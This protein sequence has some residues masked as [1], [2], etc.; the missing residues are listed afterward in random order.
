MQVSSI[1]VEEGHLF[2][3]G[4]DNDRMG[5]PDMADIVDGIEIFPPQMVIHMLHPTSNQLKRF[6]IRHA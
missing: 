4:M 6:L 3:G 1:G 5:M 2:L